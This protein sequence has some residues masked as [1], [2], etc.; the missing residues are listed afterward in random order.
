MTNEEF[1]KEISLENE[2]W[3]PVVGWEGLYVVSNLGRVVFLCRTVSNGKG[4]R[5]IQPKL[6]KLTINKD[7]YAVVHIH[8]NNKVLRK[9]AHRLVAESFIPNP[10]NKPEVDH[11]NAIRTDNRVSN[12]RWVTS[13]ENANNPIT[14]SRMIASTAKFGKAVAKI[15]AGRILEV[16]PSIKEACRAGYCEQ[17][18]YRSLKGE[19]LL[20]KNYIWR[21][22]SDL[23]LNIND[24]KEL[25]GIGRGIN[26]LPL[27]VSV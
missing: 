24:V 3:R 2:E 25:V 1:L 15:S 18:I 19:P 12:L 13:A 11:I 16:Y 8:V 6:C 7:G 21:L 9:L 22:L 26:P 14:M 5:T 4:V 27:S 20:T 23:N 10:D 17:T